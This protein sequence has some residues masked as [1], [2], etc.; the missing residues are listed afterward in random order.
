MTFEKNPCVDSKNDLFCHIYLNMGAYRV[1][2]FHMWV[3]K[4]ELSFQLSHGGGRNKARLV[5]Y[6]S[7]IT[8]TSSPCV[9]KAW[10]NLSVYIVLQCRICVSHRGIFTAKHLAI[11]VQKGRAWH[12]RGIQEIKKIVDRVLGGI[13]AWWAHDFY[14]RSSSSSSSFDL[15][16]RE[17]RNTLWKIPEAGSSWVRRWRWRAWRSKVWDCFLT[18]A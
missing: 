10:S 15:D 12:S 1:G 3:N 4:S 17:D 8:K 7:V 13:D 14:G 18:M 6:W 16:P 5:W 9:R 11:L 2:F